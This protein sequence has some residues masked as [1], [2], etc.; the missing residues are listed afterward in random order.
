VSVLRSCKRIAICVTAGACLLSVIPSFPSGAVD[1]PR[2][3]K[4]PEGSVKGTPEEDA[5]VAKQASHIFISAISAGDEVAEGSD[6]N[7]AVLPGIPEGNSMS[8]CPSI[9]VLCL[10]THPLQDVGDSV[11]LVVKVDQPWRLGYGVLDYQAVVKGMPNYMLDYQRHLHV[12]EY[13]PSTGYYVR[14]LGVIDYS[15]EK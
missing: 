7:G 8:R 9:G 3:P 1:L 11:R 15:G 10:H 13:D 14:S 2:Y 5:W 6:A 12:L 4:T